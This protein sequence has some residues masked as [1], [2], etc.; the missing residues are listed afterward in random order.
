MQLHTKCAL[1]KKL[2]SSNEKNC[3]TQKFT[4]MTQGCKKVNGSKNARFR[5]GKIIIMYTTI[6]FTVSQFF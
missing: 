3:A 4:V 1:L 2:C 6:Y 5:Y